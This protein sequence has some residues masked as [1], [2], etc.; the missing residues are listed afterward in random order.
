[1]EIIIKNDEYK[2][3][4]DSNKLIYTI[5]F[6]YPN[7]ILINSIL[8]PKIIPGASTDENYKIIKFKA[9]TV[10]SLQQFINENNFQKINTTAYLINSLSKQLNYLIT[11]Q[12]H[13]ILGYSLEHIIVINEQKFLFLGGDEILKKIDN[14]EEILISNPY[15]KNDFFI[16]P[17]MKKIIT[18][19]FYTHY[20]SAYFSLGCLAITILIGNNNFYEEY[21]QNKQNPINS[22][23]YHSCKNTKLYWLISRCLLEEPK[24]RSIILI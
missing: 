7:P 23:Q 19:P 14:K 24:Q 2:L 4:Y 1:M 9:N 17:E 12:N 18:L 5:N 13:S 20:K 6:Q 10:K 16:A 15:T 22:L 3:L 8:N 21:L 11:E